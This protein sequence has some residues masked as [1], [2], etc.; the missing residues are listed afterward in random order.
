MSTAPTAAPNRS[1]AFDTSATSPVPF[2]RL[3]KVE[4]RKMAD[5]RAGM[6]LLALTGLVMVVA[7]SAVAY[8]SRDGGTGF[9]AYLLST[10]GPMQFLLPI[11][12]IL[13]I[14]GEWT[15]RTTLS[16]FTL[17]PSRMR[18]MAAK[19]ASAI[20]FSV[21]AMVLGGVLAALVAVT[22]G[23]DDPF[24]DVSKGL[25]IG[26]SVTMLIA[27]LQGVAFGAL[28]LSSAGA[29]VA[30]FAIPIVFSL[31]TSFLPSSITQ[32]SHWYDLS[33][34]QI[35]LFEDGVLSSAEWSH[36]GVASLIWIA[37]PLVL[38]LIRVKRMEI[39]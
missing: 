30:F 23:S 26:L 6:W 34:A 24:G 17:E 28:L 19:I 36:L 3:I 31:V 25:F 38:G 16:T 15:Q 8:Q 12:G 9:G 29:I 1:H 18:L 10:V 21:A 35:P 22:V 39:K 14:T 13:L 27:V 4:L 7:I 32:H 5:T 37:L 2:F 11:L 20:L 33:M